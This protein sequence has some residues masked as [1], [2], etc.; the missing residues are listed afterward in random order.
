VTEP[1]PAPPEVRDPSPVV[2][3]VP[4]YRPGP[5]LLTLVDQLRAQVGRIVVVDDG[6]PA[7]GA[8]LDA[9]A[10]R[11]AEMVRHTSNRGIAAALNTGV[12][13]ALAS[14]TVTAVLTVDQ[15]SAVPDGYVAA[16]RQ[17]WEGA[18]AQGRRVGLVAPQHVGGLPDQ[19][20]GRPPIQSGQLLP[21]ATWQRV[22]AFDERLF[23]DGVDADYAL[24][25]LDAGLAVVVA[26]GVTLGHHLGET[27]RVRFAGRTLT[28]TRSAPFRYYYL[29]RNRLRLVARHA[30]KHPGWAAGQLV[31]VV[32]HLGL[33]IAFDPQRGPR[34]RAAWHGLRDGVRGRTGA[35]P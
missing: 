34:A 9:V 5:H 23:I 18:E 26:P 8:V 14:G 1:E 31:G 25:C 3:V 7:S 22:G 16:L 19:V 20:G 17:A 11:G 10:E 27:Y 15:D 4:A 32:G 21:A 35:R 2:A 30:R 28:L 24:R 13:A 6:G 33:V 12:R 29:T